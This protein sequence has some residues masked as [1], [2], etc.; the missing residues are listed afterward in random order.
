MPSFNTI[1]SSVTNP[2]FMLTI[3]AFVAAFA[4]IVTLGMPVLAQDKLA[5]RLKAVANRREE[6]RAQHKRELE[7]TKP[8][9]R[10]TSKSF[11]K[12]IVDQLNLQT[13]LAS[14]DLKRKLAQAGLR[15]QAPFV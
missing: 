12:Q 9:L 1:V 3:L 8:Q 5:I 15:G 2:E 14:P 11:M 13:L 7:R 6:L 4:T 10:Q